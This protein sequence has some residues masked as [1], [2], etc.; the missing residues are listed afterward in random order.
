[1]KDT[2]NAVRV[3]DAAERDLDVLVGLYTQHLEHEVQVLGRKRRKEHLPQWR[4]LPLFTIRAGGIA[5]VRAQDQRLY[6]RHLHQ[7]PYRPIN[8]HLLYRRI[9]I[10]SIRPKPEDHLPAE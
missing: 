2:E 7:R 8:T 5:V 4:G 9:A 3:I 6:E 1:M 10:E